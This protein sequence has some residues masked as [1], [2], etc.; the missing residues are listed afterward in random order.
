MRSWRAL[1]VAL[2][3]AGCLDP[4]PLDDASVEYEAWSYAGLGGEAGRL[5]AAPAH[6]GSFV[7]ECDGTCQVRLLAIHDV[8]AHAFVEVR[9]SW[10][11]TTMAGAEFVDP[12]AD[13]VVQRGFDSVRMVLPADL[14]TYTI[15][16]DGLVQGRV[17]IIGPDVPATDGDQMLPDIVTFAPVQL[18]IGDCDPYEETEQAATRCLRLGNAVGNTG[19][20]PLQVVLPPEQGALA[21][22]DLGSF[23][24]AIRLRDGGV[25]RRP[26][27]NA[28]IHLTHG[29]F[30]YDGF[31]RFSLYA[32]DEATGL[33][34]DVAA[35]H[36]KSGFCFLDWG[37]MEGRDRRPAEGGRADTDCLVPSAEG[38]T[39]GVSEG[40]FDFYWAGLTDQYIDIA[41]VPDGTYELVSTADWSD[42]LLEVDETDNAASAIVRITGDDVEVLET[43]SFFELPEDTR[44]L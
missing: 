15:E 40:W 33:R 42:S 41:G 31:A 14:G 36:H 2:A 43:R 26:V 30:H 34:G 13:A 1:L 35:E 3:L 19:D 38:W 6:P 22:A 11:G 25:E 23:D 32:Y 29:H 37:E 12:P 28:D 5:E 24:Q 9:L 16:A 39:M 20:G 8:P 17:S 27:G 18:R 4:S 21:A 44:N 7:G 10:D